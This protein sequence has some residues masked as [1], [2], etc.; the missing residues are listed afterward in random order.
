MHPLRTAVAAAFVAGIIS[1]CDG[2][3]QPN[4][5]P[6][7]EN[8]TPDYGAKS[9][10]MMKNANTGMDPKKARMPQKPANN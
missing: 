7:P 10:D 2:E 3:S 8:L 4:K 5:P 1:G 9:G 6:A